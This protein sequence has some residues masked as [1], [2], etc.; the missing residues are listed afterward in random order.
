MYLG[1]HQFVI[2]F[3]GLCNLFQTQFNILP[4]NV[5]FAYMEMYVYKFFQLF[6]PTHLRPDNTIGRK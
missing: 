3:V 6:I 4:K 1:P 2:E 5:F